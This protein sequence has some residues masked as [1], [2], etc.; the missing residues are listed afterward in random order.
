MTL[1]HSTV[2]LSGSFVRVSFRGKCVITANSKRYV[3]ADDRSAVYSAHAW[4][5]FEFS[6]NQ[7]S[8]LRQW[9]RND[10]RDSGVCSYMRNNC[11][12]KYVASIMLRM[13]KSTCKWAPNG[14]GSRRTLFRMLGKI[15]FPIFTIFLAIEKAPK[16][17]EVSGMRLY[18][19]T[20]L[21]IVAVNNQLFALRLFLYHC[22]FYKII[23]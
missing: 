22:D 9:Q 1:S 4:E 10:K 14:I 15:S 16:R 2:P 19:L 20:R 18:L 3:A 8:R 12:N 11:N 21:I 7:V 23:V 13:V 17:T 5:S 6:A